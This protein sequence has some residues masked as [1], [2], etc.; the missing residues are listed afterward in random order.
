SSGFSLLFDTSGEHIKFNGVSKITSDGEDVDVVNGFIHVVDYVIKPATIADFIEADFNLS[1]FDSALTREDS[2]TFKESLS[3][4]ES[5]D[6]PFTVFAPTIS[7]FNDLSN[8]LS[9]SIN[10]IPTETLEAAL[11]LH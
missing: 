3:S 8:E 7:A 9:S 1:S 10:N 5:E 2:F 11:N 6:E 4:T